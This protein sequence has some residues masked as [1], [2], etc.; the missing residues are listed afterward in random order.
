M[1]AYVVALIRSI[2]DKETYARYVGQVEATLTPFGG[3]FLARKPD[4]EALEGASGTPSRA[5]IMQFPDENAARAWHAS[6]AY[7]PVM[8]LR[9]SA[10]DGTLLL[11]PAVNGGLVPHHEVCYVE[12]V[13]NDVDATRLLLESIHGWRFAEPDPVLGGSLVA[14]LPNGGRASIRAPLHTS[15]APLTRAYVRVADVAEAA[16][17]AEKAGAHVALPP[18]PLEGH[19]TIAIL[20]L[21]GVEH[22][23]WQFE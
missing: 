12:H 16:K 2:H 21:G 5:I 23:L 22:G 9:R 19:G 18:T 1:P 15:E 10:S 11:L 14:V 20:Q 4:P 8:R 17:N 6:P 7:Q 3:R 13:T